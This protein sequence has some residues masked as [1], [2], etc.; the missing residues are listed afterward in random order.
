MKKYNLIALSLLL[1]FTA[2]CVQKAY[3]KTVVFLLDV[4]DVKNIK[5]VGIRGNEKPLSW[6]A[7]LEMA[8]VIKD[9]L[10]KATVTFLTGYKF[11]E[12]KFAVNGDFELKDKDNRRVRFADTD[13][14]VYEAKFE[15][16]NPSNK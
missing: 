2:G 4:K 3:K 12:M 16:I 11:T 14:T 5:K 8:P 1:L 9:T 6:D 10:Y 13:T 15:I 7:D